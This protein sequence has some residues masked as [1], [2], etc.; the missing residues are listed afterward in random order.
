MED[1]E[2]KYF[3]S[4]KNICEKCGFDHVK[5]ETKPIIIMED[6]AAGAWCRSCGANMHPTLIMPSME[7]WM[8][9]V[10]DI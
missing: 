7:D 2:Y 4:I 10:N 1:K 5:A 9:R 8:E 3:L 6:K